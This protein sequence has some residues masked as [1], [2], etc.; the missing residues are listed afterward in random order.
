M[1][2]GAWLANQVCVQ[3]GTGCHG[4][5]RCRLDTLCL[6]QALQRQLEQQAEALA[7]LQRAHDASERQLA[8]SRL[9]EQVGG[10]EASGAGL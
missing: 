4:W 10:Q 9:R 2:R 1:Q 7:A 6:L 5:I 3:T 8:R